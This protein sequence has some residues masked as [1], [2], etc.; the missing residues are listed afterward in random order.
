MY[1]YSQAEILGALILA[2]GWASQGGAYPLGQWPL[3]ISGEPPSPDSCVTV[4]ST[5]GQ[6]DARLMPNGQV[7]EH[8]GIQ[9]RVRSP[10]FNTGRSYLEGLKINLAEKIVRYVVSVGPGTSTNQYMVYAVTKFGRILEIGK[11]A[12]HSRRSIFTLN[13]MIAYSDITLPN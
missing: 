9:I 3:Y 10:D 7:I 8:P 11:E 12:S 5:E 2:N 13:C 1:Y 6:G 4:F